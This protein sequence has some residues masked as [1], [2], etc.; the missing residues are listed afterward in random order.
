[1]VAP[2]WLCGLFFLLTMKQGLFWLFP[3]KSIVSKL[4][5]P[6]F[7]SLS[8]KTTLLPRNFLT[9]TLLPRSFIGSSLSL[10]ALMPTQSHSTEANPQNSSNGET[11]SASSVEPVAPVENKPT[12]YFRADY[13]PT[14]YKISQLNLDFQLDEAETI[15]NARSVVH[16]NFPVA[17]IHNFTLNGDDLELLQVSINKQSLAPQ[18]YEVTQHKLVILA[19]TIA[20][21]VPLS[22]STFELSTTVKIK[23]DK[24]SALSGL[25]KSGHLLCTQCEAMGFRR[26]TYY[27]DRPDVLSVYKVRLEGDKTKYPIL[28]SNGNRLEA[29]EVAGTNRHWTLWEDPFPKPS[30][31]FA[32]VAGDLAS[33]HDTYTTTSGRV[34]QLGIYADHEN[35]DQLDHA[36]YS[37]KASMKW[38]EDTF[39]LECDLDIYNVVATNYF[40][41]GAM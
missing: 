35:R 2:F 25:Y 7:L 34:V 30:Y 38:D 16:K 5:Q 40:N 41:M 3:R 19:S 27:L 6:R 31:L 18:Q 29:G 24:N 1:M 8:K 9:K 32:L 26:I 12:E 37:L 17:E 23:P 21:L 22:D 39:G 14:L 11:C 10:F 36:M 33:I 15:V 28:L 20:S 4:A 13:Q